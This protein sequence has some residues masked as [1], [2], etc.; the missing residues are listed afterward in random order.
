MSWCVL[1][2][3]A[4]AVSTCAGEK[5]CVIWS[6]LG[7]VIE[8]GSSFQVFCVFKY[9]CAFSMK[10]HPLTEQTPRRLNSTTVYFDVSNITMDKTYICECTDHPTLD[11]CG[12]D[13]S[14]E[15]RPEK[16]RSISCIC[17]VN[18]NQNG[19]V[20][21]TW[22]KGRALRSSNYVLWVTTSAGGTTE[23]P[24][25]YKS[26]GSESPL[27]NFTVLRSVQRI[28]VW[29][30]AENKLASV[31]SS[32]FN[33]TLSDI[34][35][36]SAPVLV[37]LTCSS[38][39]CVIDVE[40]SAPTHHLEIQ[41]RADQEAWK[42]HQPGPV[43]NTNSSQNWSIGSLEPFRL[44]HFRA[45][46]RFST[47]LW[48]D[49]SLSKSSWTEEEAPA[50]EPDV[51]FTQ[52]ESDTGS[53]RVY[54]KEANNSIS[55][56]RILE[57][58]VSVGP[59]LSAI[60][61]GADVRN[62]SISRCADC[63]LAVWA[64]NSKGQSPPAKIA[65][66]RTA[67][68]P[69]Q[70]V[71]VAQSNGSVAVSWRTPEKAPVPTGYVVEWYP[72]GRRLGEVRW[73]R[74]GR[75]DSRA[76][77]SDL[78]PFE[79]YEAAVYDLHG[80]SSGSGSRLKAFAI[81][82]SAPESGPQ[83][84]DKVDGNTVTVTWSELPTSQRGGCITKY[85]LYL[86]DDAGIV[87]TFSEAASKRTRIIS[88][89]RTGDYN[90]WMSASTVKGEGPKSRKVKVFIMLQEIPPVVLP[91]CGVGF[92]VL[93]LLLCS[94]HSSTVKQ[95]LG[96]FSQCVML[97]VVPDPANSKWARECS[98]EKDDLNIKAQLSSSVETEEE[99][100]PILVDV[101]ELPRPRDDAPVLNVG[102]SPLR[103]ET[104]LGP[105]AEPEAL[106][107]PVT[108]YIKSFSHDSDTSE[109]THTSVDTNTTVDYISSHSPENLCEEDEDGEREGEFAD[110]HFSP[111]QNI[112]MESLQF[113]GKLT[114]DAVKIDCS[115]FLQNM[116]V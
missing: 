69:P 110:I 116:D 107:Y 100:E 11:S 88:D 74:L 112:F 53:L 32:I 22:D 1:I 66:R 57:Y 70:D 109:Q 52:S 104:S 3:T 95:K 6:T 111:S 67:G 41:H 13:V 90:L 87:T 75:H 34:V 54:W 5:S 106:L 45:R 79:C 98:Q 35:M 24:V 55:R 93:L 96:E 27:A 38:R 114:L 85:T 68:N 89:L 17:K 56:G 84:Y 42:T 51:W 37:Q 25:S 26:R 73:L 97:D 4:A 8:L 65:A 46:S 113:G 29:V 9:K 21:C 78:R 44:Y 16:P 28:S 20:V 101:E 33:Y 36:P 102:A 39:T 58:G 7:P 64:R 77:I 86:E 2:L 83:I 82:E 105:D 94:C 92:I 43:M 108:T 15:Y 71:R 14:T 62:Y 99:Q 59:G 47:G 61:L 40:E 115:N 48:S 103:R 18:K 50:R 23:G 80:G 63:Q 60:K 19:E 30:Q 12:L 91:M 31:N 49:W 76:L 72:R 10:D 81:L